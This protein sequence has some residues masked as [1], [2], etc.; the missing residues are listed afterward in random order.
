MRGVYKD[1]VDCCRLSTTFWS[2]TLWIM[3]SQEGCGYCNEVT[4]YK[5]LACWNQP[6]A[7]H[8][9][10]FIIHQEICSIHTLA[11]LKM[12]FHSKSAGQRNSNT[13]NSRYS[14]NSEHTCAGYWRV[15][16]RRSVC[17]TVSSIRSNECCIHRISRQ[18]F[19]PTDQASRRGFDNHA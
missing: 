15:F 19:T 17:I 13:I 7:P 2:L 4:E 10:S 1:E 8:R 14:A 6:P 9:G 18:Y 12:L 5:D 3:L 16:S 11:A